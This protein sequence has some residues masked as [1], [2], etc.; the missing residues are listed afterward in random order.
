[1]T[2]G[3][4]EAV[5]ADELAAVADGAPPVGVFHPPAAESV[6][7]T[8]A[9]GVGQRKSAV[10]H[11]AGS[12]DLLSLHKRASTR[13]R[14]RCADRGLEN[15]PAHRWERGFATGDSGRLVLRGPLTASR[16]LVT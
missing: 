2:E 4:G 7:E 3:A 1:M 6:V 9:T 13:V 16:T 14:R 5:P 8:A 12:R 10:C 15:E 11:R